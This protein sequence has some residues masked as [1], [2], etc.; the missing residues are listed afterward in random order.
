MKNKIVV[1]L[2]NVFYPKVLWMNQAALLLLSI[3]ASHSCTITTLFSKLN[4][5]LKPAGFK[6]LTDVI[7]I[8]RLTF[9]L[10]N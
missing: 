8:F 2:K 4:H 10:F 1:I 3:V 5:I 6:N 9:V 7:N